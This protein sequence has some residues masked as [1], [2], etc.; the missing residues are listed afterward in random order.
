MSIN[1]HLP[2]TLF[3]QGINIVQPILK[4]NTCMKIIRNNSFDY[5]AEI[6]QLATT[7]LR[8]MKLVEHCSESNDFTVHPRT[9]DAEGF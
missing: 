4:L 7:W 8:T 2:H 1:L 9:N 3:M 6:F 5:R